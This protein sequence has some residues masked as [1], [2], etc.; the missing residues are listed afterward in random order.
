M[1]AAAAPAAGAPAAVPLPPPPP[2]VRSSK[3][4]SASSANAAVEAQPL[5]TAVPLS[6]A[7][8]TPAGQTHYNAMQHLRNCEVQCERC[9]RGPAAGCRRCSFIVKAPPSKLHRQCWPPA[10]AAQ[11][12]TVRTTE[13]QEPNGLSACSQGDRSLPSRRPLPPQRRRCWLRHL[14]RSDSFILASQRPDAQH[15]CCSRLQMPPPWNINA[16]H[17]QQQRCSSTVDRPCMADGSRRWAGTRAPA[18]QRD[19]LIRI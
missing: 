6:L 16:V 18:A 17:G 1:Q 2:C 4:S 14:H 5:A 7:A 13:V 19:F 12:S 11:S 8:L 10:P 9:G 15:R 3:S